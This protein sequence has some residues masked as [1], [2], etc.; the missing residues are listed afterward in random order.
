MDFGYI[1]TV[2]NHHRGMMHRK[3]S[4]K[5][6]LL[7]D[8]VLMSILALRHGVYFCDILHINSGMLFTFGI[9]TMYHKSRMYV[10]SKLV[11]CQAHVNGAIVA[12]IHLC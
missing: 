2:I 5:F 12:V 6:T 3:Y 1:D 9:V 11:Q 4:L 7:Q 10:K 8:R